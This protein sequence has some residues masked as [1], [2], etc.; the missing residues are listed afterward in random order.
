MKAMR[1]LAVLIVLA[2]ACLTGRAAYLHAKAKLAAVLI[3][4]AWDGISA[5]KDQ[6]WMVYGSCSS[7]IS[8]KRGTWRG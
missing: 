4:R 7:M 6:S 3:R 1:F 2:G 8:P 5:A